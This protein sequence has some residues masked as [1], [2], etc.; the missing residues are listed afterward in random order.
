M[1]GAINF[2]LV[3]RVAYA[4]ASIPLCV[5]L[6]VRSGRYKLRTREPANLHLM[7]VFLQLGASLTMLLSLDDPFDP[8]FILR[9]LGL[10]FGWAFIIRTP[11]EKVVTW[12]ERRGDPPD[13]DS[14]SS[15]PGG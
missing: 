13:W 7:A 8:A 9:S 10:L 4:I 1:L 11:M 15:A 12:K 14:R 2:T 6:L 3:F 5:I